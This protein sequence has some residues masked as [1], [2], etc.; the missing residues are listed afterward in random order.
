MLHYAGIVPYAQCISL[1]SKR[2]NLLKPTISGRTIGLRAC[3]EINEIAN[4]MDFELPNFDD[5]FFVVG[6][7][8]KERRRER[9]NSRY[10]EHKYVA[11]TCSPEVSLHAKVLAISKLTCKRTG[12]NT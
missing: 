11:K 3:A 7:R 4:R 1:C 10:G 2:H 5:S 9:K 8:E 6:A 12:Y